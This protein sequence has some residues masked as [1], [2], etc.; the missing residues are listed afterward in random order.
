MASKQEQVQQL[1]QQVRADLQQA[2]SVSQPLLES[3]RTAL[4]TLPDQ[5]RPLVEPYLARWDGEASF[6]EQQL[7]S[8]DELLANLQAPEGTADLPHIIEKSQRLLVDVERQARLVT[9]ERSQLEP[10]A[11][12]LAPPTRARLPES[13][14]ERAQIESQGQKLLAAI[15]AKNKLLSEAEWIWARVI[16]FPRA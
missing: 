10:L 7:K 1:L 5:L 13:D 11:A 12:A 8:C 16:Q 14:A 2:L 6:L 3:G 15:K 4:P 9:Q